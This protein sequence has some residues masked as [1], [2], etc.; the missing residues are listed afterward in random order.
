MKGPPRPADGP[1]PDRDRAARTPGHSLG[2]AGEALAAL[3]YEKLGYRVLGT[4][5]RT[6]HGEIDLLVRRRRLLVAVEVKTR[7]GHPAPEHTVTAEQ[8]ARVRRALVALAPTVRPRPRALRV[9]VAAVSFTQASRHDVRT[10][11]GIPWSV[12]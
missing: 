8:R 2:A 9:D 6:V 7:R 1:A 10:F 4:R 5:V 12:G 3:A 11:P